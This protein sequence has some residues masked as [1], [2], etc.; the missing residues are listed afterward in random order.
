MRS[1]VL[2][3]KSYLRW[4]SH[5]GKAQNDW[6]FPHDAMH[7][8]VEMGSEE[9]PNV[10]CI[11]GRE[12]LRFPP[13]REVR[14]SQRRRALVAFVN[15]PIRPTVSRMATTESQRSEDAPVVGSCDEV[16]LSVIPFQHVRGTD[17]YRE[18]GIR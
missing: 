15:N 5:A 18:D 14:Q 12:A 4:I 7:S 17:L 1:I 16:A 8:T 11:V 3:I 10:P 2:V 13:T 9:F 6:Y